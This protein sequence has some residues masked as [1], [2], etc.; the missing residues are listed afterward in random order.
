MESKNK[1]EIL[2]FG[3]RYI[4]SGNEP[5]EY[6]QDVASYLDDK[7][8]EI[9]DINKTL[10]GNMVT[11]LAAINVVDEYLKCKNKLEREIENR[12]EFMRNT[13]TD[14]KDIERDLKKEVNKLKLSL[15]QLQ[16]VKSKEIDELKEEHNVQELSYK[17][18]IEKLYFNIEK[19]KKETEKK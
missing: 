15:A 5:E 6:I 2:I 19:I 11:V 3:S 7:M 13:G 16:I 18:E 17:K 1:T 10:S 14:Q 8:K 9:S 12:K 4:V